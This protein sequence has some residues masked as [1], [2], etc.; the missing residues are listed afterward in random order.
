[1]PL[2]LPLFFRPH[3]AAALQVV[4]VTSDDAFPM[5]LVV[6]RWIW[7]RAGI[8]EVGTGR[9]KRYGTKRKD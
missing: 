3:L 4:A 8:R 1:M 9:E 5:L 2:L 7:R 6:E